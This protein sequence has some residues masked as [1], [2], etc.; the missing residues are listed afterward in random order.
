MSKETC[1][2]VILHDGS[3]YFKRIAQDIIT[4]CAEFEPK[5]HYLNKTLRNL[6]K[7]RDHISCDRILLLKSSKINDYSSYLD[8]WIDCSLKCKNKQYVIK[9]LINDENQSGTTEP[10]SDRV[11]NVSKFE[12]EMFDWWPKVLQ[13][14]YSRHWTDKPNTYVSLS[15]EIAGVTQNEPDND[16][17]ERDLTKLLNDH[18]NTVDSDSERSCTVYVHIF[19]DIGSEDS[20][21]AKKLRH[22]KINGIDVLVFSRAGTKNTR[23]RNCSQTFQPSCYE[24]MYGVMLL[25]VKC[26][27]LKLKPQAVQTPSAPKQVT[28]KK[29]DDKAN[30]T[31]Q[32]SDG[33]TNTG[34]YSLQQKQ[35]KEW[36]EINGDIQTG[37]FEIPLRQFNAKRWHRLVYEDSG[38]KLSEPSFP[39]MALTKIEKVLIGCYVLHVVLTCMFLFS[40]MLWPLF[41]KIRNCFDITT[42]TLS[43]NATIY[44]FVC[45]L[46]S[47]FWTIVVWLVY[48]DDSA[49]VYIGP[50]VTAA[51]MFLLFMCTLPLRHYFIFRTIPA[52]IIPPWDLVHVIYFTGNIENQFHLPG[53]CL[54]LLKG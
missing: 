42:T 7:A 39:S 16:D 43:D 15:T 21:L 44:F 20:D 5:I 46:H 23:V 35:E 29:V 12:I 53:V 48:M 30:F 11:V 22:K 25:L 54:T 2:V 28:V 9:V 14:I 3:D 33:H 36:K 27:V 8:K 51:V 26:G 41:A 32:L 38:G 18:V 45:W 19:N 37:N 47:A 1:D 13:F 10:D 17:L 6:H 4:L 52:C 40:A 49:Y 34:F 50:C 31:W 24:R